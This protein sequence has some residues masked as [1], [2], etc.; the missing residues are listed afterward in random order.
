MH[1]KGRNALQ[2]LRKEI[3]LACKIYLDSQG[4][5]RKM[6]KILSWRSRNS[7]HVACKIK[8]WHEHLCPSSCCGLEEAADTQ[9]GRTTLQPLYSLFSQ[10]GHQQYNL[11]DTQPGEDDFP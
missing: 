2:H 10:W 6:H 5:N 3:V 7:S 8:L 11:L 4:M 9:V 1:F